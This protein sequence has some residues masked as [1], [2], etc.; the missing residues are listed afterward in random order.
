MAQM[1]ATVQTERKLRRNRDFM[2]L[3][4]GES[5]SEIGSQ[6]TT[7]AYPL[8]VLALTHSPAKAGVV[9]LAAWLPLAL[10]AL[11]AGMLADRMD[12]KRVM[13]AC[14]AG[15]AVA[16]VSIPVALAVGKPPFLQIVAVALL[17]GGLAATSFIAERGAMRQ[18][19]DADQLATAV[20]MHDARMHTA[21]ITGP[22]LGGVL[23]AVGR[24]VPFLV[25]AI[26]YAASTTAI[27]L[28]RSG[29]QEPRS[30]AVERQ[31][32]SE[33][34]EGLRWLWR[35]PFFRTGAL[36]AAAGNPLYTGMY[37]LAVLLAKYHGA[38]SGAVG[39]MFAIV[40]AG[41]L[42]GAGLAG[43]LRRRLAPRPALMF[44]S[45]LNTCLVPVLLVVHSPVLIGLVLACAELLTPLT[46]SS[47]G[48]IRMTLAPDNLQGRVQAA[49]TL[50]VMS[51]AWLGP[52]AV[53]LLFQ[54][55]GPTA[56][57][58]V[59]AAW[60]AGIAIVTTLSRALRTVPTS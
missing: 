15:R 30:P 33:P 27:L 28:T 55:T 58:L 38:S 53:G 50:L 6:I 35:R 1:A 45:W 42:L 18:L 47:F 8:L 41:G 40:G 34:L 46:N 36:L 3:W 57:V 52:L 59:L 17:D 60:A 56:T 32:W 37:L 10:A 16:L 54:L 23:F 13:I 44:E 4:S 21:T 25:D 7:V 29:F 51:L 49:N 11:P 22:P 19:V 2:L 5:L 14:D 48:A 12:R 20:T 9:G 26:S 43:R 31:R 39:A 24:F